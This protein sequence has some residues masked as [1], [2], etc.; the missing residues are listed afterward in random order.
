MRFEKTG[1]R[2]RRPLRLWKERKTTTESSSN[3]FI[4]ESR[5]Q[6]LTTTAET[7]QPKLF[8]AIDHCAESTERRS[9]YP[10]K[11]TKKTKRKSGFEA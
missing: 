7:I 2:G 1:E 5:S 8:R 4:S 11:N 9:S 6:K 3:T 10:N